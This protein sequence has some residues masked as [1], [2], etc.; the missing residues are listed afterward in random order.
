MSPD[1]IEPGSPQ[2]WL[3]YAR[4]DLA[5]ARTSAVGDILRETLAF[6]TQQAIE[7]SIKAV[8]VHHSVA[9]PYTHDI[10]ILC[11]V[12]RTR[13]IAWSDDLDEVAEAT[14]YAV[15][16]RYPGRADSMTADEHQRAVAIAGRVL[17]WAEGIIAGSGGMM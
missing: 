4:S 16:T 13:G 10:A 12:V 11:D 5:V 6:H 7:K 2:D 3:R 1:R 8:L 17:A 9:F 14:A 15:E